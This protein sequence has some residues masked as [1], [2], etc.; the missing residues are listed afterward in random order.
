MTVD[1]ILV[2]C[3][4]PLRL[5]VFLPSSHKWSESNILHLTPGFASSHCESVGVVKLTLHR[6]LISMLQMLDCIPSDLELRFFVG[7]CTWNNRNSV[8]QE[9]TVFSHKENHSCL[10]LCA[11][12]SML[13]ILWIYAGLHDP[14][15]WIQKDQQGRWLHTDG[16]LAR[17][18]V[19]WCKG[20]ILCEASE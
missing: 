9:I 2:S 5:E 8:S 16:H 1:R 19:S 3:L 4:P 7:C 15:I 11:A 10:G 6:D 20:K 17:Y 18:F 14:L 12:T 13:L